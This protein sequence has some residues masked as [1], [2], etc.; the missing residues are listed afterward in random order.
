LLSTLIKNAPIGIISSDE[1][2]RILLVNPAF[3]RICVY[4]YE[5]LVGQ[6][7]PYP[8]WDLA[9]LDKI[10]NEFKLAISAEKEQIEL[11][12]TRKNGDRVLAR[13]Q[14]ITRFDDRGNMLR[15]LA[16][17]ED[18]TKY[19][20]TRGTSQGSGIPRRRHRHSFRR[21]TASV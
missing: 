17:M 10:N 16:T 12:V 20:C 2:G 6:I 4:S 21:P 19:K 15:H 5:E 11:W 9:D 8:Y 3:E 14:P 13:L 1:S 18:I 7:P